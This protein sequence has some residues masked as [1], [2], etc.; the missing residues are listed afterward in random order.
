MLQRYDPHKDELVELTQDYFDR[1]QRQFAQM[2][3][4]YSANSP[5]N[6]KMFCKEFKESN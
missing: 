6:Y 2:M 1:L 4:H 3:F 5:K